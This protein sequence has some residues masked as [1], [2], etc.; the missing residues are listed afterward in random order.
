MGEQVTGKALSLRE[1]IGQL[2]VFGF[3]GYEP[4][5]EIKALI[6]D[7]GVGGI[8]YFTRNIVDAKQVH[9]LSAGL[10]ETAERSGRSPMFIA[11]D[12]EGGMVSRLV[13]GVTLMPGNMALGATG[14]AG[15]V[16][17]AAAICGEQ[18]R[19]LGINLNYA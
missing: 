6:E 16:F 17:E 11:V 19:A 2:F 13:K 4:S 10:M 14:S 3:H 9:A 12:Q 18:L 7:Y 1:K 5:A 8:I 15:G